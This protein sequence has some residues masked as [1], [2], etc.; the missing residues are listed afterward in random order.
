MDRREKIQE[1]RKVYTKA[2]ISDETMVQ[3]L[4]TRLEKDLK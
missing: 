2:V 4:L 3:A 1:A